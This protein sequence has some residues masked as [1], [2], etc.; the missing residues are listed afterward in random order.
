MN[1]SYLFSFSYCHFLSLIGSTAPYKVPKIWIGCHYTLLHTMETG[2][3]Q[4]FKL[5]SW[6]FPG[7]LICMADLFFLVFF[8]H[9]QWEGCTFRTWKNYLIP[10]LWLCASQS[11][12]PIELT[13]IKHFEFT[14]CLFSLLYH[15]RSFSRTIEILIL[16]YESHHLQPFPEVAAKELFPTHSAT[17]H[18]SNFN[19]SPFLMDKSPNV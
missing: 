1:V 15:S 7:M 12:C 14:H 19:V 2:G 5:V 6:L 9:C 16:S 10:S 11:L 18:L 8:Y 4:T 17:Y 13:L 3:I